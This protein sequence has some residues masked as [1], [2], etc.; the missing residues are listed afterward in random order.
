MYSP[1]FCSGALAGWPS[2]G[3]APPQCDLLP[4]GCDGPHGSNSQLCGAT[5]I[6]L[7]I[8]QAS[9]NASATAEMTKHVFEVF[10]EELTGSF[11]SP[12][13]WSWVDALFMSMST[14]SR[15]GK[16]STLLGGNGSKHPVF[17]R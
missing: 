11:I 13:S 6:E 16:A 10:D 15:L 7:A 9:H 1:D 14:L 4:G 3:P 17:S 12:S 8:V 2:G 5:Y